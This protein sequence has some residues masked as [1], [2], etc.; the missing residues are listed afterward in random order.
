MSLELGAEVHQTLDLQ[1]R[2]ALVGAAGT[3]IRKHASEDSAGCALAPKS[4][5]QIHF[6]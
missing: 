2:S 1:G 4:L 5:L 3:C 6:G